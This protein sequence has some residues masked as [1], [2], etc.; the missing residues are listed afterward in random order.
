MTL[1]FSPSAVRITG[2]IINVDGGPTLRPGPGDSAMVLP[3]LGGE[4]V[5]FGLA[6]PTSP[7]KYA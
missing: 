1:C 7:P 4:D 3:A 5:A 2:P 6:D